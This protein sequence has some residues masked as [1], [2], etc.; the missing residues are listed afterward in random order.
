MIRSAQKL[1]T[2]LCASPVGSCKYLDF[3]V[4]KRL[5]RFLGR[6]LGGSASTAAKAAAW[7]D[8]QQF[9]TTFVDNLVGK[10]QLVE[11]SA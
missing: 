3:I 1:W 8:T 10:Q 9:C 2:I 11:I 5:A 7:H 4:K 6:T